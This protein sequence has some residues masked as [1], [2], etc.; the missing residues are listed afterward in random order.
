MHEE[1]PGRIPVNVRSQKESRYLERAT[2][3]DAR[4]GHNIK[5]T[6]SFVERI[7]GRAHKDRPRRRIRKQ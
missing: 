5:R 3:N 7:E 2:R 6:I 4:C 1:G